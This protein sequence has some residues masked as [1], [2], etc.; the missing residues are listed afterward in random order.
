MRDRRSQFARKGLL[1]FLVLTLLSSA[2]MQQAYAITP[3]GGWGYS[4]GYGAD[5]ILGFVHAEDDLWSIWIDPP[6]L[7]INSGRI[8]FHYDPNVLTVRTYGW[9][10]AFGA[11]PSLL[12][13]PVTSNDVMPTLDP[14]GDPWA[15]QAPNAGLVQHD[16]T[17]DPIAGSIVI[18]FDWGSNPYQ[19]ATNDHFNFFGIDVSGP[20]NMSGFTFVPRGTGDFGL[21]GSAQDVALNGNNAATYMNCAGGYCGEEPLGDLQVTLTPEP[22]A[23]ALLLAGGL[24]GIGICLGRRKYKLPRIRARKTKDSY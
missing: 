13:P 15:M 22:G 6:P 23:Y 19:P 9:A 4:I 18:D 7:T 16:V 1:T 8:T 10:G 2:G 24:S 11:D 21:V 17:V 14:N 3:F 5:R 12:A 20:T